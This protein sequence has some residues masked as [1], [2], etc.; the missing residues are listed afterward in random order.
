MPCWKDANPD[1]VREVLREAELTLNAQVVFGTSADQRASAL[2]G[3]YTAAAT[4][5]LA[6]IVATDVS[7][8]VAAGGGVTAVIFLAAAAIC[9]ATALP[10]TFYVPG[11]APEAWYDDVD[12]KTPLI[13]LLGEQAELDQKSIS[14]NEASLARRGRGYKYGAILGVVAPVLGVFVWWGVGVSC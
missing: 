11:N 1:V 7:T 8:Q 13:G 3:I 12:A 14:H 4:A 10:T 5:I 2:G 6:W 9:I